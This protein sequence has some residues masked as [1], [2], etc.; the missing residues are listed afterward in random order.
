MVAQQLRALTDLPE[1][2]DLIPAPTWQLMTVCNPSPRA[3]KAT[4]HKRGSQT[5]MQTKQLYTLDKE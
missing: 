4:R 3:S 2:L 5:H 1:D